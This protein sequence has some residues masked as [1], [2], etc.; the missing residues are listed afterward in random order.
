MGQGDNFAIVH[1]PSCAPFIAARVWLYITPA[2]N[3]NENEFVKN[4][5]AAQISLNDELMAKQKAWESTFWNQVVKKGGQK[6]EG[7]G[8]NEEYY[9]T[10]AADAYPLLDK[11]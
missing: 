8:F 2:N 1:I 7:N 5:W 11:D 6:F 3:I 9:N 4:L 10:K